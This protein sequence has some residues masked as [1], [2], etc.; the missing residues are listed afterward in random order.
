MLIYQLYHDKLY[1][2]K[3]VLQSFQPVHTLSDEE[4]RTNLV[5]LG[6]NV[7]PITATTRTIYEKQLEKRLQSKSSGTPSHSSDDLTNVCITNVIFRKPIF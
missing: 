7:G 2:V 5:A 6:A 1:A 3:S 4:L